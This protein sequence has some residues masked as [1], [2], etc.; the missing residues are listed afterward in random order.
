L[1]T[2]RVGLGDQ[3]S[4]GFFNP[5]SLISVRLLFT[6]Q[7]ID[8]EFFQ[9]R[10]EEALLYRN[11]LF[12]DSDVY[13]LVFGESDY[14]PG[15]IIDRYGDYLAIQALSAGIDKYL[16]N[17][18]DNL[19]KLKEGDLISVQD[20]AGNSHNFVITGSRMYKEN[21]DATSAFTSNDGKAHLNLITCEGFWNKQKGI[22]SSRLVVFSDL[23]KD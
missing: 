23:K 8:S 18:I 11:R 15:L 4:G 22:Y 5:N 2:D 3:I 21:D 14:L 9:K 7:N 20:S 1:V 17:Y 10:I 19:D 13:R 12:P 6:N 16:D